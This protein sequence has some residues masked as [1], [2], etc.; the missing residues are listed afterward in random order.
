MQSLIKTAAFGDIDVCQ[1]AQTR[2][3]NPKP[4]TLCL[5]V[6]SI[7]TVTAIR[8]TSMIRLLHAGPLG[9]ASL[10][11]EEHCP[12]D[13]GLSSCRRGWNQRA[14][15]ASSEQCL[16][17]FLLTVPILHDFSILQHHNSQSVRYFGS[18][19]KT[20]AS[21]PGVLYCLHRKHYILHCLQ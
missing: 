1:T 7:S 17:S 15:R 18:C 4:Q 8:S 10:H 9:N 6:Q 13:R 21:A 20:F 11:G 16:L 12:A 5:R 3:P 2:T 14:G 19:K